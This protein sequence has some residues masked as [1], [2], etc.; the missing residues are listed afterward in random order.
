MAS[1]DRAPLERR[2]GFMLRQWRRLAEKVPVWRLP[3]YYLVR[4]GCEN[5]RENGTKRPGPEE[6]SWA[7][8]APLDSG[9]PPLRNCDIEKL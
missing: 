4:A 8:R 3:V 6:K 5:Y 7:A 2:H 9:K 1:L